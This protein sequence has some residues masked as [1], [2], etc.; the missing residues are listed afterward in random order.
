MRVL[1]CLAAGVLLLAAGCA[2]AGDDAAAPAPSVSVTGNHRVSPYLDLESGT[3]DVT[4]I[5]E[6]TGQADYTV[7]FVVANGAGDC[8][9][10]WGGS[11]ALDDSD[12]QAGLDAIADLGGQITVATGGAD[13]T[14]LEAVCTAA[15]LAT[16]YEKALDAAGSNRLD[17]DILIGDGQQVTAATVAT[18]LQAVQDAR[19]TVVSITVPVA[20]DGDGLT[21]DAVALLKSMKSAGVDVTVNV[22]TMNFEGSG[23][24]GTAMTGAA[25]SVRDDVAA[26]WTGLSDADVYAMLGVTP[27]IGVNDSGATTTVA[28]A[29]TLLGYAEEKELGYVRFWS[30]NRDNDGCADGTVSSSCSGIAQ[31][32][33]AFTSLF[34]AFG[35]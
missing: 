7:A 32:D 34:A 15:E 21:G 16:A 14:Y 24:W 13:G 11:A 22:M 18:A 12:V 1:S 2:G 8:T 3:A 19:D 10:T 26:V 28:N 5:A 27:M 20:E 4:A 31:T 33:Y 23:D 30:V 6:A 25:E 35:T 9:A 17:V 29:Q